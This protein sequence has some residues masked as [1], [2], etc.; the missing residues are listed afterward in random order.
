MEYTKFVNYIVLWKTSELT[1]T[2]AVKNTKSDEQDGLTIRKYVQVQ[3]L[4]KNIKLQL[5]SG[6]NLTIINLHT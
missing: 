6:S 3:I 5:D 1:F 2:K 4:N